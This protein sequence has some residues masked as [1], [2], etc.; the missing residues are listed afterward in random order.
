MSFIPQRY[1]NQLETKLRVLNLGAHVG[2][3]MR[4]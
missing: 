4:T 1:H 2:L 3:T